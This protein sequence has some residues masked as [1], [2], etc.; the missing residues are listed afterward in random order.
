MTA[1]GDTVAA[2]VI[3]GLVTPGWTAFTPSWTASGAAPAIGNGTLAGRYRRT[4]GSDLVIV[5]WLWTAGSTTTFGTGTWFFS[6]PAAAQVS[7]TAAA[8]AVG[9]AYLLDS[10]T[11]DKIG[12]SKCED[13]T[14]ITIVSAAT[15]VL[16]PTNP[17]TWAQNDS[18]RCMML[19]E[20]A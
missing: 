7:A 18:I 6:L 13:T 9:C 12:N 19:F 11:A 17:H 16:S 15:G 14:K 10:G 4:S 20:P 3:D 5:E 1:A 8:R 2:A